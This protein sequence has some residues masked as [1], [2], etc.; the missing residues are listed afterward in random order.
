MGDA[1]HGLEQEF[2]HLE[3][4]SNGSVEPFSGADSRERSL[5]PQVDYDPGQVIS[6]GLRC[7]SILLSLDSPCQALARMVIRLVSRD[8]TV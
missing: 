3:R 2:D 4:G 1:L 7:F 5:I 6:S 8:C